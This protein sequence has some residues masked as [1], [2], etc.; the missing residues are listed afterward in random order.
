ML[1]NEFYHNKKVEAKL[2]KI[3]ETP[4]DKFVANSESNWFQIETRLRKVV[5]DVIKPIVERMH[6]DR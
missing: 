5:N 4:V 2:K 1:E 6:E 3:M